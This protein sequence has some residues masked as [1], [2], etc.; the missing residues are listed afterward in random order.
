[1]RFTVEELEEL[2]RQIMDA[3]E[4]ADRRDGAAATTA[5]LMYIDE[6]ERVA[7]FCEKGTRGDDWD[8]S[9]RHYNA[10]PPSS[11]V[12]RVLFWAPAV[13]L[14]PD[15]ISTD[16]VNAGASPWLLAWP[17]RFLHA[18]STVEEFQAYIR[19]SGGQAFLMEEGEA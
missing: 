10:G 14:A 2:G 1:M 5:G 4:Q 17:D 12:A 16:S 11:W 6:R 7:Y 8:D 19:D 3:D 18:H 13:E 15:E 9:P